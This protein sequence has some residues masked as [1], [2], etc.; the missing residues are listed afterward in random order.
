MT[1]RE[2]IWRQAAEEIEVVW[3]TEHEMRNQICKQVIEEFFRQDRKSAAQIKA[4][5]NSSNPLV[6]RIEA[7]TSDIML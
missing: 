2:S 5:M 6:E 7:V 1:D 4:I 3:K